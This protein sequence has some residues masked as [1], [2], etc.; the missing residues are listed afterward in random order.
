MGYIPVVTRILHYAWCQTS[1]ITFLSHAGC[2]CRHAVYSSNLKQW[3][4]STGTCTGNCSKG[5]LYVVL[6]LSNTVLTTWYWWSSCCF[7]PCART[8]PTELDSTV[9][10][11]VKVY[12]TLLFSPS[13]SFQHQH[14]HIY[15]SVVK[16]KSHKHTCRKNNSTKSHQ[17]PTLPLHTKSWG[18]THQST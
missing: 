1:K 11:P 8:I 12:S 17:D 2:R 10:V 14:H 3:I 4:T 16:W 5:L 18:R 13:S 6:V 15:C 9:H 7:V